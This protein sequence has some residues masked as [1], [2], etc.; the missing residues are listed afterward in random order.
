MVLQNHWYFVA[1]TRP[2]ANVQRIRL[3]RRVPL[4]DTETPEGICQVVVCLRI[5]MRWVAETYW[6]WFQKWVLQL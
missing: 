1:A 5:L 2:A 6:P 3:W 4:G